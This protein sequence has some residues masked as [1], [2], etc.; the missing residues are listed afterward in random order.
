MTGCS[1]V[2]K[3][4]PY[5]ISGWLQIR[6]TVS[7]AGKRGVFEGLLCVEDVDVFRDTLV[8]GIGREK[9]YGMG[10]LTI[11]KSGG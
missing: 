1:S 2:L 4:A 5:G 7:R 3:R 6:F 11:V 9:A 8:N 10:M